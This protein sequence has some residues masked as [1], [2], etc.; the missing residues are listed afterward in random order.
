MRE[1]PDF[2]GSCGNLCLAGNMFNRYRWYITLN[3]NYTLIK[4]TAW[5][6]HIKVFNFADKFHEN[7]RSLKS[8][9]TAV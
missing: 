7:S 6:I 8:F 3:P 5:K 1:F 4:S 9:S 2:I